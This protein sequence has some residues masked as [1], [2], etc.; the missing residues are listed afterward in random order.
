[1]AELAHNQRGLEPLSGVDGA[2]LTLESVATPMHVGS[3]HLFDAPAG[4]RGNFLTAVRRMMETGLSPVLRRQLGSLP[5]GLANPVW[6]QGDVDLDH[7]IRRIRLPTPGTWRQ[8]QET[9]ADLHAQV[10][11]RDHPLWMLYVLEGLPGGQ[12]ACYIKVHHAMLDGQAGVALSKA[13]FSDA[14]RA[15][16]RASKRVHDHQPEARPA[17][18]DAWTIARHAIRHDAAQYAKLARS[19]PA[20]ARTV[21]AVLRPPSTGMAAGHGN[22]APSA[23]AS[24]AAISLRALQRNA[25]LGPRTPL[26]VAI[27]PGRSFATAEVARADLKAIASAAGA[28]VNDVVLATCSGALRRYLSRHTS[29]PRKS[30]VA[31]M[32]ISLR[33]PGNTDMRTQATLSLVS[34]AS[35][36]ADPFERLAAIRKAAAATKALTQRSKAAIPTDL[37]HLGTT[38]LLGA[39]AALYGRKE[40]VDN[41]PILANVLISNVPGPP[42]PLYVGQ[43]RMTGYWPL[44]IVEHGVGLNITL[45]DYAGTLYFG[46][47]AA[48]NAMPDA[49]ELAKDFRAALAEWASAS[50]QAS[51]RVNS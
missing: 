11:D 7:H 24:P 22:N 51:A 18:P 26:N 21:L 23:A 37:P 49:G 2:F 43:Y 27:T 17:A 48:S 36:K 42:V 15:T 6:Y 19:L 40:A 14:P 13:L 28:T 46:F 33:D 39:L 30:L 41:L 1:M 47:V 32:P 8:L 29:L 20:L 12:K 4:H 31:S 10:L 9:V 38:W 50:P 44:S 16:K 5:L 35:H 34:L 3:L 45:V 25:A